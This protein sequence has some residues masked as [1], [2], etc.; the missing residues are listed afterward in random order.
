MKNVV[1]DLVASG[2]WCDLSS[3]SSNLRNLYPTHLWFQPTSFRVQYKFWFKSE[4][5]EREGRRGT[6]GAGLNVKKS[7]SLFLKKINKNKK[8]RKERKVRN[9]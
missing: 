4:A 5:T 1:Y 6:V 9:S 7:W 3:Y 2:K 8:K